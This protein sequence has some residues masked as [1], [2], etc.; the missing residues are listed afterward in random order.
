MDAEEFDKIVEWA[1]SQIPYRFRRRLRNLVF[2]VEPEPSREVLERQ[3][4]GPGST[5]LGLYEGRPLTGRSVF[6]GTLMPDRITI[7]QRPHERLAR[8]RAH[9]EEMVYETVWHEVAHYFGLDEA[10]VR[11]AEARRRRSAARNSGS[12]RS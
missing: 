1:C 10:Q 12:W 9:L 4:I 5:L 6:D 7:F 2:V 3:G 11:A 8:N